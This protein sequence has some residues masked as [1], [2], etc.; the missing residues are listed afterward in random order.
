[1]FDPVY[2]EVDSTLSYTRNIS[3]TAKTFRLENLPTQQPS[4][5]GYVWRDGTTLR[6]TP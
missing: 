6:I 2:Y 5:S 3:P 4:G 1:M